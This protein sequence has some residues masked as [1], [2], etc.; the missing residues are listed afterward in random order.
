[1]L[2][3]PEPGL[4]IWT[5]VTFLALLFI[6]WKFAWGPILTILKQREDGIRSALDEAR[7]AREQSE[8]LLEENRAILADAQNQANALLERARQDSETRRAEQI[9]K[10][11]AETETLLNRSREEIERQKRAAIKEIR[12]ESADL[13]IAAASRLVERSLDDPAHRKLVDD[14]FAALPTAGGER[15]S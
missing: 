3:Q 4:A 1:M 6:L 9:E 5:V 2:I 12:A 7:V 15:T 10:T 13:V 11:R 8:A 14:Y